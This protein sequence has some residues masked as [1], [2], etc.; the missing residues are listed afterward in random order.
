MIKKYIL[1]CTNWSC[2]SRGFN[3][4]NIPFGRLGSHA[5]LECGY[6]PSCVLESM[7]S[8]DLARALSIVSSDY[9]ADFGACN[10]KHTHGQI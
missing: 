4:F 7:I 6:V 8:D 5:I 10:Q 2:T 9:K 3:I 1:N